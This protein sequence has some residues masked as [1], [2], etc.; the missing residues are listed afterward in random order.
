MSSVNASNRQN[1]HFTMK[2]DPF[3]FQVIYECLIAHIMYLLDW[4]GTP[5]RD[6]IIPKMLHSVLCDKIPSTSIDLF[7]A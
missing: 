5:S 3:I 1:V 4:K 7:I 6:Y 2:I